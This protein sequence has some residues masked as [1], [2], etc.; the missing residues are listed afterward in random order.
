MDEKGQELVEK[1]A[2]IYKKFGI[3]SVT[4][5]D[6]ARHLGVSKKTLYK[7]FKDKNDIVT[8]SI[9]NKMEAEA[10]SVN[11]VCEFASNAIDELMGITQ[12]VIENLN[13]IHPSVFYD[14]EKYYP[15]AFEKIEEHKKGFIYNCVLGNL[16]RGKKEGLYRS[17]L[18]SEIIAKLYVLRVTDILN[19]YNFDENKFT[20]MDLYMEA[21]RYHI[22]GIAS[23]KGIE[24]Q[25]KLIQLNQENEKNT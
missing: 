15:E 20:P 21:F 12:N 8:R 16:E 24:Y 14:L 4:M 3:K 1:S 5:D 10:C 6:L 22:R 7:Y 11:K 23:E 9:A 2:E 25:E 19:P 17:D 18:N 13:K